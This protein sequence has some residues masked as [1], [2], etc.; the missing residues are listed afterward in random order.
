MYRT[1]AASDTAMGEAQMLP[2]AF[3]GG[4]YKLVGWTNNQGTKKEPLFK[5]FPPLLCFD[6]ALSLLCSQILCQNKQK[7]LHCC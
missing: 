2:Q 1:T 4:E 3:Q 6:L 7:N 5:H